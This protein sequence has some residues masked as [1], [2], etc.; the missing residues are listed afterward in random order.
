VTGDLTINSGTLEIE[1][2][3]TVPGLEHDQLIVSGNATVYGKLD[4]SLLAGYSLETDTLYAIID[5]AGSLAGQF[6]G[7]SEGRLVGNF[8]QDLFIT[9][10]GGD[11]NDVA[12][13][14]I[15]DL[16]SY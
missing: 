14:K 2:G 4:V 13:Y 3:G 16:K 7:L 8:G 11:G 5:V 10:A 1:L 15:Y 12:L 6:D 9:D